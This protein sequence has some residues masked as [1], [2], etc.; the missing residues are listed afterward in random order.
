[1]KYDISNRTLE[2]RAEIL[3]AMHS[4]AAPQRLLSDPKGPPHA[5]FIDRLRQDTWVDWFYSR[6]IK[7]DFGE[8]ILDTYLFE[9]DNG[10]TWMEAVAKHFDL[11]KVDS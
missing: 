2:E 10:R 4:V 9:R 3:R 6:I 7:T 11:K 5:A 1:M 8:D